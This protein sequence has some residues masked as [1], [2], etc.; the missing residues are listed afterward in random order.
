MQW[1][2]FP[3]GTPRGTPHEEVSCKFILDLGG[4]MGKMR[5][6]AVMIKKLWILA[7]VALAL[8]GCDHE[9]EPDVPETPDTVRRVV[10]VYMEARNN[11]YSFAYDDLDEMRLAEIPA[12]CRLL[13]YRSIRNE[14]HPTLTEI[15]P[16]GRDTVLA[17]YDAQ[18]SAVDPEQMRRV[19]A[20]VKRLAPSQELGMVLWSHSSGWRQKKPAARGYGLENGRQM[21]ISDLAAALKGR[22]LDFLF[23]DTCYMGCVEVAY[24]LRGVAPWLVASV[25]EVPA[26]GMPYDLTLPELFDAD[27]PRGLRK[28]IDTNVDFYLADP[29]ESCP[30]TMS[31][32]DLSK[33][34]ALAEA[35]KPVFGLD[36]QES[37]EPQ[38]FSI[39]TPYKNLFFDLGQYMD[40]MGADTEA[41]H[42]AVVHERHTLKIW[43]RVE[44]EHCSGLSVFIPNLNPAYTPD[45]YD[46]NTLAWYRKMT[47]E[48]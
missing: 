27:I 4:F 10:L 28:A 38:R 1:G 8:I 34:D 9:S 47:E 6:F 12:D 22:G 30:S 41:L 16:D 24:E 25:C 44:L 33:M 18:A 7:A 26:R 45:S 36:L 15:L 48:R 23:F 42:A 29:N 2:E 14:E 19:L 11:L 43:G 32:I 35:V 13:T 5:K 20:D 37:Y 46:Y 40:A 3:R 39:S 17:D 31:L 21:K